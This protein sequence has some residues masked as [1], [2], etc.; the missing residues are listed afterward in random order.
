M[1]IG[2]NTETLEWGRKFSHDE[3]VDYTDKICKRMY[4]RWQEKIFQGPFMRALVDGK[5]PIETIRL[6]WKHWYSYP[7]EINNFH[8]IIYQR[9]MGFF[10]RHPELIPAYVGKISDELIHPSIPGHIQ[11]LIKQGETFKVSRD[12]M[13]NCPVY[14]ECRALTEFARGLLYEGT[15][16]EWWGRSLNEEMFGH[17]SREWRKALLDKYQYKDEEL[18]YFQVHEE[19]DLVEHDDGLLGHGEVARMI[20][21]TLLEDGLTWT[22]PGWSPEYSCITNADYVALFHDGI[23][24]HAKEEGHF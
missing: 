17:W 11:V 12:E 15:L 24:K 7:V 13:V 14:A 4:D 19:A 1:S 5:L 2:S 6:F 18:H 16:I 9:H 22:R 23:Y 20:F 21:R 10:T 3:A 8:L